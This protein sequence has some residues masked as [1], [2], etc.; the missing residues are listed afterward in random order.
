[1]TK[2]VGPADV[3]KLLLAGQLL[4]RA[5][6]RQT[7]RNYSLLGGI[8]R[9]RRVT[10]VHFDGLILRSIGSFEL[11]A[12]NFGGGEIRFRRAV[13]QRNLDCHSDVYLALFELEHVEKILTVSADISCVHTSSR[14]CRSTRGQN[15]GSGQSRTNQRSCQIDLRFGLIAEILKIDRIDLFL[16]VEP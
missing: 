8:D 10:H 9:L 5:L 4:L 6:A 13:T 11:V 16:K 7:R 2:L 3:V 15:R 14:R 12:L 1:K